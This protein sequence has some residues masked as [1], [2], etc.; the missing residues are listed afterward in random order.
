M[1]S[2]TTSQALNTQVKDLI[3]TVSKEKAEMGFF[4][5]L[6]KPTKVM[7]T[8]AAGT[9]VYEATEYGEVFPKIQILTIEGLLS[10]TEKPK[11]R[12]ASAGTHTFKKAKVQQ[13]DQ[14]Q[15][16]LF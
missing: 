5:T 11:F 3:A 6:T 7:I 9:G 1:D 10:G 15:I 12:D 2:L 16:A 8:E 4:I 13:K 14:K